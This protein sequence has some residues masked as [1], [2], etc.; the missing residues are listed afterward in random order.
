L[1]RIHEYVLRALLDVAES[2]GV[3]LLLLKFFA[4]AFCSLALCLG[5]LLSDDVVERL[6]LSLGLVV[7]LASILELFLGW[8]LLLVL[9]HE[10]VLFRGRCL[11]FY[12][13]ISLL[14]CLLCQCLPRECLRL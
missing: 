6:R 5:L 10:I 2:Q 11:L 8:C 9:E 1:L 4:L 12:L 3:Q 7:N 14:R 13:G